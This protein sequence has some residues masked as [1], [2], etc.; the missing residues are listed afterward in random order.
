MTALAYGTSWHHDTVLQF[1]GLGFEMEIILL[2][3]GSFWVLLGTNERKH[4]HRQRMYDVQRSL[5][6]LPTTSFNCKCIQMK[7]I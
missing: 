6:G 7:R 4:G 3:L 5:L 2:L 1:S